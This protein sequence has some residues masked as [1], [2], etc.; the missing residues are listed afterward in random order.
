[1]KHKP[2][3]FETAILS[4]SKG[5]NDH[6]FHRLGEDYYKVFEEGLKEALNLIK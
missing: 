2:I 1:M 4:K 6:F 5:L 3:T